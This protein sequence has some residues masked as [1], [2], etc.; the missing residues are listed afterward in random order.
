MAGRSERTKRT[1]GAP[2]SNIG[3][4]RLTNQQRELVKGLRNGMKISEAALAAGY[5]EDYPRQAGHQALEA[6]RRKMPEILDKAGLTD[7]VLIDKYLRPGLEA[8]E[9]EFAKFEGKITDS[10]DV[11]AWGERRGYLDLAFKL[12]GSYAVEA[13]KLNINATDSNIVITVEHV[14]A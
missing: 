10:Q 2:I 9:T 6:I 13:Q 4:K 5:S 7:E 3:S 8:K 14:G 1:I 11:I 12:K